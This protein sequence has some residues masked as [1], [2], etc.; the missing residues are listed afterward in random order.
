MTLAGG[1]SGVLFAAAGG[2]LSAFWDDAV[3]PLA[4]ALGVISLIYAIREVGLVEIPVPGRDWQVPADWVRDGFYRSAVVFG[5][6]VGFGVFT[7]VPYASLPI[8]F[9]WLFVSGNVVYGAIVGLVYGAT[10]AL[11]IY[12]S[13]SVGG[14]EQLVALNQRIMRYAPAFHQMTGLA[15]AAFAGYLLVAP[16]L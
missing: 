13:Y 12:S 10:R 11:S 6:T 8:M 15:L 16:T 1:V 7:R 2:A 14:P 5:S 4:I 9:A 3:V